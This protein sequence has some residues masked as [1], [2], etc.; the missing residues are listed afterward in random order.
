VQPLVENAMKHGISG[1]SD[2]GVVR[3]EVR[4][5]KG[6]LAI[7]VSNAY[8]PEY[9]PR[10]GNG[11]GLVNVRQRLHARYGEQGKLEVSRDTSNPEFPLFRA[12]I[13]MPCQEPPENLADSH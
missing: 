1:L 2:S 8:D 7:R 9:Q 6:T 3:I 4:C 12:E 5:G 11:I 10:K 13:R